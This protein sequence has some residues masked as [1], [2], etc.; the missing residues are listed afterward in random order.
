M[1]DEA[2]KQL[3]ARRGGIKQA[4]TRFDTFLSKISHNADDNS[5]ELS[6]RLDSITPLLS[7][8]DSIQSQIE[9]LEEE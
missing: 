7:D 2:K 9:E 3:I 6:T 4:L 1:A 5:I 8:Y